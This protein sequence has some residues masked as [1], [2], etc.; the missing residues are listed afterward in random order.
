MLRLF[1]AVAHVF[2]LAQVPER[3]VRRRRT[4]QDCGRR[5]PTG[6]TPRPAQLIRAAC[7]HPRGAAGVAASEALSK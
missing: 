1:T 5:G 7:L 2:C 4:P 6:T 3:P